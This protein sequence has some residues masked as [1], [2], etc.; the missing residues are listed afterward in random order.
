MVKKITEIQKIL[1][2]ERKGKV[3][4]VSHCI[5]NTN[6]RYLGGAFRG[7]CVKEIITQ[8]VSNDTS[9]IQMPCP[10]QKV[11]GGILKPYM[12]LAFDCKNTIKH[13]LLRLFFPLFMGYT[14]FRY[15]Q[16]AE[17]VANEIIDYEKA[18]Y[19]VTGILG[20]DGSPTCGV[21]KGMN[22]KKAFDFYASCSLKSLA[23]SDFNETLYAQCLQEQGG[24][25]M[26]YLKLLL[27]NKGRNV[28]FY[29]HSLIDE[30]EGRETT[31]W[32]IKK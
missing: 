15:R 13:K 16:I 30:K 4:F 31:L 24:I 26:N 19:E 2:D 11:W 14:R 20:I 6:A 27:R 12:W 1:Q 28:P 22:M 7:S 29:S 32:E 18:G 8:A 3:L 5:L 25:F 21:L 17:T 10:E 9:L 23:R